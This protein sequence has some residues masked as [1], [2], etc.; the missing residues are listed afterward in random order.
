MQIFVRT[1]LGETIIL[2]VEA[3]DNIESVKA[4]IRDK[5]GTPP[6][7]QRLTFDGNQLEDGRT[8]SD[9]NIQ[10]NSTLRLERKMQIYVRLLR[11]RTFAMSVLENT[12]VAKVK[13]KIQDE[14]GIPFHDQ[15]L[16]FEG[17]WLEDGRKMYDYDIQ[18]M[19][20][21]ILLTRHP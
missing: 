21:L 5:E 19:S 20:V 12:T 11:G 2:D 1:V 9:Y 3:G 13:T 4:K 16:V 10:E 7:Q 6:D 18:H 8:L 17:M 14:V 15:Q